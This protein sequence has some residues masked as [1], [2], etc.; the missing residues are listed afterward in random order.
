MKYLIVLLSFLF[1]SCSLFECNCDYVT[2]DN[3]GDGWKETYRSSWD[4]CQ[5]ELIDESTFTD[6][7]DGSVTY[8]RTVIEC[9]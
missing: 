9:D 8:S 4:D 7:N 1:L 2:Y 3:Y 5:E 6:Y